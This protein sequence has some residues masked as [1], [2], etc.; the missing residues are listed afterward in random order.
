MERFSRLYGRREGELARQLTRYT[1]LVKRHEDIFHANDKP[2]F[3]IS[4]PG[5]TEILGNHTDHNNGRVMAAAINLDTLAAVTPREDMLVHIQSAGFPTLDLDFSCLDIQE[6]EKGTS[7]ALVKGVARR[8]KDLGFSIGGF[9][10]A[11]TSDVLGGSGLSSSA[12]YEVLICAVLD[13]LY[14][15]SRMDPAERA[16]ISQYAENVYFGKPSGLMDQMASSVGGLV[17]IDFKNL[18]GDADIHP[19]NLDLSKHGYD[20]VVVNTKG[21]HDD[22][23]DEYAAIRTEMNDVAAFFG[24]KVLR[25]VR[26]DEFMLHI[27]EIRQKC[28]DRA[29]L[30]A[31][32]FFNENERVKQLEKAVRN[33]DIPSFLRLVNASGESSRTLLQN[34]H[35]PGVSQP[36]SLALMMAQEVLRDK[37]ALRV[38]GGG[39]AGTT[40]NVVP[41]DRLDTFVRSMES[42]FGTGCCYVLSIRPEGAVCVF[43]EK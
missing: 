32:H 6:D 23:T 27:G 40:L 43:E 5:R 12:A 31:A 42:V 14:N 26:P 41:H 19:L 25:R 9:D 3:L 34:I 21:S 38:H 37:G 28:S 36:V 10:A 39:F 20:L 18:P 30:R 15:G 29:C 4:A 22:L 7:A 13:R 1:E 8:M 16:K 2:L 17:Y 35:V 33:E 24:E 11:I